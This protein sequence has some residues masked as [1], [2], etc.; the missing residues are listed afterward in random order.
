MIE[1]I[2]GVCLATKRYQENTVVIS[3][4]RYEKRST[5][6]SLPPNPGVSPDSVTG[7]FSRVS[8]QIQFRD[9]LTHTIIPIPV[10]LSII[11]P[12]EPTSWLSE[13]TKF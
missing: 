9:F 1:I 6:K 7:S 5:N 8:H 2:L 13:L 4:D 10:K 3:T 11:L 12:S